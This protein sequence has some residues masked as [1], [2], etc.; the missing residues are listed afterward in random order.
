M[1]YRLN[2]LWLVLGLVCFSP[3]T[4][5]ESVRRKDFYHPVD[6]MQGEERYVK[7][8]DLGGGVSAN[9]TIDVTAKGNGYMAVLNLHLKVFDEHDDGAIY[10]GGLLQID[11]IDL[12]GGG[13]KD[14][15][16]SGLVIYTGEKATS[17]R[18]S[19]PVVFIYR[20]QPKERTFKLVYKRASFD[21][22]EG[23]PVGGKE[24][25]P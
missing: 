23:P 24:D 6:G 20:F 25:G 15:V 22:A 10:D 16:I 4:R 12:A 2:L 5:A 7:K 13:F 3:A 11:F 8:F 21:L 19:E 17:P 1:F 14:L 18:S 9:V